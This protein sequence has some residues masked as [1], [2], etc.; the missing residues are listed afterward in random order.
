MV[1]LEKEEKEVVMQLSILG[2]VEVVEMDIMEEEGEI[3]AK[4]IMKEEEVVG[5]IIIINLLRA[6]MEKINILI[7]QVL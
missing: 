3:V 4:H 6:M 2:V 5:Q 7:I 1:N